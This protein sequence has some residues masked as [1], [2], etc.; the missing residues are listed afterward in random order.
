MQADHAFA[1]Q[2]AGPR[3]DRCVAR[4]IAMFSLALA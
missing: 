1:T 3:M 4:F 2:S